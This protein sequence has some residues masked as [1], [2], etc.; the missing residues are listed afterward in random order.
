M[1]TN[2][3][4]TNCTNEEEEDKKNNSWNTFVLKWRIIIK[5]EKKS[6]FSLKNY[7]HH[8]HHSDRNI[9]FYL[10]EMILINM[11]IERFDTMNIDP[12]VIAPLSH[13]KFSNLFSSLF[14]ASMR[15]CAHIYAYFLKSHIFVI[16]I[17]LPIFFF[18][19]SI[20]FLLHKCMCRAFRFALRTYRQS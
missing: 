10:A 15:F 17:F 7:R 18:M 11:R 3:T 6:S 13:L 12:V 8:H 4:I 19:S 1:N 5:V 16:R 14:S 20:F 9:I 2:S